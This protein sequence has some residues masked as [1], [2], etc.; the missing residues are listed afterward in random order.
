MK[1]YVG[2]CKFCNDYTEGDRKL[3]AETNSQVKFWHE[4]SV[5]KVST[6]SFI[7][8]SKT[9]DDTTFPIGDTTGLVSTVA[10]AA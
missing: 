6:Y 3:H 1:K 8:K 9:E 7:Q 2:F 5:C 10:K 4:C